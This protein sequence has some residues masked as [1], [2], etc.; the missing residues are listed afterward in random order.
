[1]TPMEAI[2]EDEEERRNTI[3]EMKFK[4][5]TPVPTVSTIGPTKLVGGN[6]NEPEGMTSNVPNFE[7]GDAQRKDVNVLK[8]G[9]LSS[10]Q[11]PSKS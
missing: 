9:N 4:N 1:M 3:K 10:P 6:T 5:L 11:S 8:G 2:P 7:S